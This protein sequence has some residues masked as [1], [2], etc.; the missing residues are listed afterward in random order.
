MSQTENQH[1]DN[2]ATFVRQ[3]QQRR[4]GLF[5]ELLD[6]LLSNK[7][8][9]MTPIILSLLL[10]GALIFFSGTAVAPFIYTLF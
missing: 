3:A 10:V 5:A 1:S 7:K 4:S 6:F 8:W 9:W 2:T